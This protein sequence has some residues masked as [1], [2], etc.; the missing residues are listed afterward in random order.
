M[1]GWDEVI[2]GIAMA[3]GACVRR[4]GGRR[5]ELWFLT[6]LILGFGLQYLALYAGFLR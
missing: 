1:S 6:S 4:L 5:P 3:V 2:I